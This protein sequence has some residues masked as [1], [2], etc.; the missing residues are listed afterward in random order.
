MK[1]S[2]HI[3]ICAGIVFVIGLVDF[4]VDN[5]IAGWIVTGLGVIDL[6]CGFLALR[7]EKKTKDQYDSRR[8]DDDC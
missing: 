4:V 2:T 5:V 8:E 1:N 3:F 6:I 7:N